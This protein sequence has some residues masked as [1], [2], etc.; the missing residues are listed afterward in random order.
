L[1]RVSLVI[2]QEK[3]SVHHHAIGKGTG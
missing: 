2:L 1:L 3:L